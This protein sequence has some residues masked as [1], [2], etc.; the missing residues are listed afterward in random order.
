MPIVLTLLS[1]NYC[2]LCDEMVSGLLPLLEKFSV[3]LEIVDIDEDAALEAR[4]GDDVPL[5]LHQDVALCHYVL[6]ADM[7]IQYINSLQ[8]A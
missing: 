7:L 2:H 5:L 6:D 4:Y 1:R 3:K 8:K